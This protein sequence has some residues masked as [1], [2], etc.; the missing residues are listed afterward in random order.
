M[1]LKVSGGVQSPLLGLFHELQHALIFLED[2]EVNV[3]YY[4][5]LYGETDRHVLSGSP[6]ERHIEKEEMLIIQGEERR[7]AKKLGQPVRRGHT[8]RP[9]RVTGPVSTQPW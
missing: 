4:P 9:V 8:G 5:A 2:P 6:L 3:K 1:G 7:L